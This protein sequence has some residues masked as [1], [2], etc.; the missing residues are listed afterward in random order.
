[1]AALTKRILLVGILKS[2]E[3]RKFQRKKV[4]KEK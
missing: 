4:V 1:V 2:F 3:K